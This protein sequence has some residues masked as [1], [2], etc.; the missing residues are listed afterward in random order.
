MGLP[1]V[2]VG[3]VLSQVINYLI[4][5][6]PIFRGM[7]GMK[8]YKYFRYTLSLFASAMVP[9]GALLWLRG[10]LFAN[11]TSWLGFILLAFLVVA[12]FGASVWLFWHRN[13]YY[14]EAV[15]TAK[16]Y[17]TALLQKRRAAQ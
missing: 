16:T 2:F 4:R 7:Y 6:F 3:T 8:P 5:P 14:R 11:G 17:L 1:G 13:H 9:Y 10:V 12:G 15:G